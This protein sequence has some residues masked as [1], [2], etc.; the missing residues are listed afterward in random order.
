MA[1]MQRIALMFVVALGLSCGR[2]GFESLTSDS[3]NDDGSRDSAGAVGCGLRGLTVGATFACAIDNLGDVY[4]WGSMSGIGPLSMA[5][6]ALPEPAIKIGAGHGH[7]CVLLASNHVRCFGDGNGGALGDGMFHVSNVAVAPVNDPVYQDLAVSRLSTCAVTTAGRVECW[8]GAYNG[9]LG[10]GE[11][12][13]QQYSTAVQVVLDTA[14]PR[15]TRI[16]SGM[17]SF[18]AEADNRRRFCWGDAA[19]MD[20]ARG[21]LLPE[22]VAI[23]DTASL[24]NQFACS[25]DGNR[26]V[27]CLGQED[28][29]ELGDGRS[30]AFE[31]TPQ[32]AIL[33]NAIALEAG[34]SAACAINS[35][36]ELYCWGGNRNGEVGTGTIALQ[37]IPAK[38]QLPPVA[39]VATEFTTT[40]AETNTG[41]YCWGSNHGGQLGRTASLQLQPQ[42]IAGLPVG[43]SQVVE[44]N[45]F[46]CARTITGQVWCWGSN[47]FGQTGQMNRQPSN[48]ARQVMVPGAVSDLSIGDD[49]VCA[50]VISGVF[51]W[52][53]N[54]F[55]Q[56][57]TGT[58]SEFSSVPVKVA[59]TVG[60]SSSLS[61]RSA[62]GSCGI[63]SGDVYCWGAYPHW[64]SV[65]GFNDTSKALR[66]FPTLPKV[67]QI[68]APP[69][70]FRAA[71]Q[72]ALT[73]V[74][75]VYCWGRNDYGQLG[76]GMETSFPSDPATIPRI[77]PQKASSTRT[78]SQIAV[79]ATRVCAITT[80][81]PAAL[82][83]WG[84]WFGN[85]PPHFLV[86]KQI[87]LLKAP[88]SVTMNSSTMCVIYVDG[89]RDCIGENYF[90]LYGN[91]SQAQSNGAFT[92]INSAI[93]DVAFGPRKNA[94]FLVGG[95]VTC[96]GDPRKGA[97]GAE[98]PFATP[99]VVPGICRN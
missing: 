77:D 83:C 81:A 87:T 33:R 24:G 28:G 22:E 54:V 35:N 14:V 70:D 12:L 75:D 71:P 55:G 72:C 64:S 1:T 90:G 60:T 66:L 39:R 88:S 68:S 42:T 61:Q 56:L 92:T 76:A 29:G 53:R 7:A 78:Y 47:F 36:H 5:K 8:G 52:G 69:H 16:F 25:I 45:S 58:V 79:S 65:A 44:G 98:L 37:T 59:D 41:M 40:C 67:K 74:G 96:A 9:A 31:S 19:L 99:T 20:G 85:N 97:L 91:T 27:T 84:E 32:E 34:R 30:E 3:A 50:A 4:C 38:I 17:N 89:T 13:G 11:D 43:I 21:G 23:Q 18:C 2:L 95:V 49:F 15:L 93:T 6:I 73:T 46:G 80:Q 10:N 63:F 62:N 86:P 82:E 94:C 57:G 26:E 51:C 48:Q